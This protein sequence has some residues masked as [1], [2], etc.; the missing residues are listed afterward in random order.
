MRINIIM[1]YNKMFI[2]ATI[3]K[4]NNVYIVI[5]T[6]SYWGLYYFEKTE[7][8]DSLTDANCW[9]LKMRCGGHLVYDIEG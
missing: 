9:L 7:I 6:Y 3:Q 8:F 2:K 4:K 5:A 1:A